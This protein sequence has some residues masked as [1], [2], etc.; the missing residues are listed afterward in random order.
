MNKIKKEE[1]SKKGWNKKEIK[2]AEA[3]LD[4]S[5]HHDIFFS[6]IVL[7]SALLVI[8]LGNVIV[9]FVAIPLMI[10]LDKWILYLSIAVLAGMIGFLYNFLI[11]DIGHLERKHHILASIIIPV[12]AVINL[13]VVVF[14]SNNL[15]K[16]LNVNNNLH[17]PWGLSILFAVSFILPFIIDQIRLYVKNK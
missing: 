15:I 9:S 17:N 10:F 4:R 7:W 14:I 5:E 8:V 13:V 1:L 11:N 12:L 2:K 16:D 3:I 6:K